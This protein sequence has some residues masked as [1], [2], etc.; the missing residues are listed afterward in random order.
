MI[1]PIFMRVWDQLISRPGGPFNFRFVLQPAVAILLAIRDGLKDSREG[2]P[3]FLLLFF[4]DPAQRM[5]LI[6][7]GW[8]SFG[9]L[10]LV[11][12]ALD[13]IY[14]S[15][16]LHWIHP[17]QAIVVAAFLAIIPYVLARGPV[18]RIA[19]TRKAHHRPLAAKAHRS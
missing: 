15:V 5:R 4:L 10:F 2:K 11:A 12:V 19:S 7:D 3:P 1:D 8:K 6:K 13:C 9:R 18:N 14:Q 17:L 16:V